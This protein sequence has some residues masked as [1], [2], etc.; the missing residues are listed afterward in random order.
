MFTI[1]L[2]LRDWKFKYYGISIES[3][4]RFPTEKEVLLYPGN[5]YIVTDIQ[6]KDG[7]TH[8]HLHIL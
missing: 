3:I 2:P 5:Q 7:K 4:S 1:T 8:I 6:K